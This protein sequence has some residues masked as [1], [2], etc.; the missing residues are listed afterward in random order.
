[1]YSTS[2]IIHAHTYVI[3]AYRVPEGELHNAV[4]PQDNAYYVKIIFQV[5]HFKHLQ[6]SIF[7]KKSFFIF[8]NARDF[9]SSFLSDNYYLLQL[10][11]DGIFLLLHL[12][13]CTKSCFEI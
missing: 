1:M 13:Y 7:M 11:W 3:D 8:I 10:L 12:F 4:S 6:S 2:Y 5:Q 9:L